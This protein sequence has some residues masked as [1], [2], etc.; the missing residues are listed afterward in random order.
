[1]NKK[2]FVARTSACILGFVP[3]VSWLVVMLPFM[4]AETA[5]KWADRKLLPLGDKIVEDI[6]TIDA[7]L[8]GALEYIEDFKISQHD[9]IAHVIMAP[10]RAV[11]F[12]AVLPF[13]VLYTLS[14]MF[15]DLCEGPL[16]RF[17]S[18]WRD[19]LNWWHE[20]IVKSL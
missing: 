1:M 8:L 9:N 12:A 11:W 19:A 10:L 20:R 16:D 18:G 3:M 15:V 5:V 7:K 4:M 2:Q 17:F 14:A 6:G 13:H